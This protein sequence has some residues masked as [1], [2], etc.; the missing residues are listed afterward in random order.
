MNAP[1]KRGL[2][3][4]LFHR[5]SIP[6]V[7]LI[8][9]VLVIWYAGAKGFQ[10]KFTGTADIAAVTLS[11][12]TTP[13]SLLM[14]LASTVWF[15]KGLREALPHRNGAIITGICLIVVPVWLCLSVVGVSVGLALTSPHASTSINPRALDGWE[16]TKRD[17]QLG[18]ANG[19]LTPAARKRLREQPA[20]QLKSAVAGSGNTSVSLDG[21]DHDKLV[22]SFGNIRPSVVRLAEALREAEADFW[23]QIRFYQ[24]SEVALIGGDQYQSFPASKF[25]QWTRNYDAYVSAMSTLYKGQLFGDDAKGSSI[26]QASTRER[27]A[28]T[29]D[30]GFKSAYNALQ[31]RTEGKDAEKLLIHMPQMN[32][33]IADGFIR[34]TREKENFWNGV[35]ALGFTEVIFSGDNYRRSISRNEFIPWCR[36]YEK[37]LSEVERAKQQMSGALDHE[38]TQHEP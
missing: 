1:P 22:V 14:L 16:V 3:G 4:V 29:L 10:N 17:H 37:Y 21:A 5:G 9:M 34:S 8:L 19:G 27:F 33:E 35:R 28:S 7:P 18:D 36:N 30:G 32:A 11:Y 12:C 15:W 25:S 2:F 13:L 26:L 24:F 31:V 38:T 6:V 23:N 20:L